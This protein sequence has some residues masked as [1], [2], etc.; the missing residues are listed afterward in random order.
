MRGNAGVDEGQLGRSDGPLGLAGRPG[1]DLLDQEDGRQEFEVAV[2]RGP[3]YAGCCRE[4]R[5]DEQPAGTAGQQCQEPAQVAA[6][7]DG[8]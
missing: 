6:A 4:R 5:G 3:G 7:L 2:Q 8:R 1:R